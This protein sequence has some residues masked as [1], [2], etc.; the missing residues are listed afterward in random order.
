MKYL[1][2]KNLNVRLRNQLGFALVLFSFIT[3][4]TAQRLMVSDNH[5]FLVNE[6]NQPFFWLADTAWELFHRCDSTEITNYLNKRASQGFNV[7]Q[8][9]ALAELDGLNTPNTNGDRPLLDNNPEKPNAKYFDYVDWVIV[10][11][12]KRGIYIALLPTWGDKLFTNNWGV[13]PEVFNQK[14]AQSFGKWIG[15]R[16]KAHDNVIWVIGGDRN[17]RDN[18]EDVDVWNQMAEGILSNYE[19][20]DDVLLT[21]HPQPKQA[22][23]SSTWFHDEKWLDFNMHQTGHCANQGTYLHIEHDYNLKPTKP[24]LDGEP[25]YEDHP[26]CFNAKELGHSVARDIR[27]IMYWNVF[28]GAFG[29]SYGCHAVWQM[30]D[31]DKKGVNQPLRPWKEALDLPMANQVKHLKNLMLSR[32]FLSRI[33]DQEMIIDAQEANNDYTSATRD[34][35]GTYAM[36]YFPQ[37]RDVPISLENLQGQSFNTWWYDTR[38]GN[39]FMGKEL[40]LKEEIQ[41]TPPTSGLGNDW[42]LVIDAVKFNYP[43]PGVSLYD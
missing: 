4:V 21:F 18:S 28:A 30:Y 19:N 37:G 36:I 33:P 12:K 17:P 8:A 10:E 32:P 35:D 3:N 31:L 38:T 22:G 42:V 11:A 24:V 41:I 20:Q 6:D 15:S 27:R 29:Q 5:R 43:K 40:T 25:L 23:G 14:N 9:V 16:F 13:G 26:N 39:S 7:V 1:S 2:L 34:I